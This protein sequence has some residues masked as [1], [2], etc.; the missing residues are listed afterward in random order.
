MLTITKDRKVRLYDWDGKVLKEAGA[1]EGNTGTISALSF[2]P[3]GKL[4]A[5]GDVSIPLRARLH[6]IVPSQV[7]WT[8]SIIQCHRK[9]GASSTVLL[10][11][12]AH[13]CDSAYND[14]LVVPL[15]TYQ[16]ICMDRQLLALRIRIVG[17]AYL[18]FQRRQAT[19]EHSD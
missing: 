13:C 16:F 11:S 2:S 17:H 14:A 5:S 15:C 10:I 12:H 4:I 9:E 8:Y 1:L 3:D 19:K 6:L 7:N 18:Y